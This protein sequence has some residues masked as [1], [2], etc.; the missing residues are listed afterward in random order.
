MAGQKTVV[1]NQTVA[2]EQGTKALD[3]AIHLP[4]S[5]SALEIEAPVSEQT[6]PQSE[7]INGEQDKKLRRETYLEERRSLAD[8]E[9]ESSDQFDKNILT[10][11]GGALGISVVFLEK[12]APKPLAETLIW[13]YGSWGAFVLCL[14]ITLSSFLTSQHA[15]RRQIKIL[16]AEIF[17]EH[18][19]IAAGKNPWAQA[20]RILNWSS[21]AVF[22]L[23]I[24]MLLLFSI[25]N[26]NNSPGDP[27]KKQETKQQTD[28]NT[29]SNEQGRK[30]IN[31]GQ[32]PQQA[33]KIRGAVAQQAPK[34]PTTPTQ[35]S[36]PSSGSSG[37]KK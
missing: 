2:C 22:I 15:Y 16:E 11:A 37:N 9:K 3:S 35:V 29:M 10:L 4:A 13:L 25:K 17:P 20:T 23:G 18:S 12:I 32:V 24:G 27:H 33:P 31:E 26:M 36:Q 21:I 28:K 5:D 14:L 34:V 19:G 6:L 8:G 30:Q 7:Q 1:G